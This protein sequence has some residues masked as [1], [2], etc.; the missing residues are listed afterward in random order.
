R[1]GKQ[2]GMPGCVTYDSGSKILKSR[3]NGL[4]TGLFVSGFLAN[5]AMHEVDKLVDTEL[6]TNK[7]IAH[8]RF[9]DDHTILARDFDQLC[10]W[11]KWYE[12]LLGKHGV[13]PKINKDKYDPPSLGKWI[14]ATKKDAP[15]APK[16]KKNYDLKRFTAISDT[17]LDGKNPTKL[18]TKTL[19]QVSAIAATD[20]H[21]LDDEDLQERLNML[22]WLLL[23]N[24]S[25][26]EIRPDTRAAFAAGQIV[27]MVQLLIREEEQLLDITRKLADLEAN[28]P[29]PESTTPDVIKKHDVSIHQNKVKAEELYKNYRKNEKIFLRHHFK[30]LIESFEKFPGKARLFFRLLQYCRIT[31]YDGLSDLLK[32]I[33][34][35]RKNKNVVWA[36][37]Y[38]GLLLQILGKNIFACTKTLTQRGSLRSD[39]S[40]ALNHIEDLTNNLELKSFLDD[41]NPRQWFHND[42]IIEFGVSMLVASKAIKNTPS[43]MKLAKILENMGKSFAGVSSETSHEEWI[44]NTGRSPGVWAFQ[45][46]TNINEREESSEVWKMFSSK[47]RMSEKNDEMAVRLYPDELSDEIW[48]H[49]LGPQTTLPQNDSGWVL[50]AINNLENRRLQA[51]SSGKIPFIEAAKSAESPLKYITLQ[52]WVNKTKK[53]DSFDPRIGEWTALEIIRQLI[54]PIIEKFSVP[55]EAEE[56]AV[57]LEA[58]DHI[59][60][61]NVLLPLKWLNGWPNKK[62][63]GRGTWEEWR[64]F[65]IKDNINK[66]Q[67]RDPATLIY[68]YRFE[69][70]QN[71]GNYIDPWNRRI[72][73]VGF[74]LLG[75]LK[76]NLQVPRIW[77]IRG[78][79][80]IF[81]IPYTQ[82]YNSL[83]ISTPTLLLIESCISART[84]ETRAIPQIPD[85]FGHPVGTN[86][87]DTKFDP[88]HIAGVNPLLKEIEKAQKILVNNQ[89]SV[90]LNQPRQLIPF[91]IRDFATGN[92]QEGIES[93]P[94]SLE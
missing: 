13:G 8:F 42:A 75:L 17:K 37:Y 12:E 66:V 11:I 55:L 36:N 94:T 60:P 23:A 45:Y 18:M 78:N 46:E 88:P 84:A 28:R 24:I 40:A 29:K 52:D 22:E 69:G 19:T 68:D 6:D 9:V 62:F 54:I 61:H 65:I 83:A 32:C 80:N 72:A 63:E 1:R 21:I 90:S 33:E 41:T 89:I 15:T 91:H 2:H 48:D 4:P 3:V 20:I 71:N 16:A 82:W 44:S 77:N 56:F 92:Q 34:N 51:L 31:G 25:E 5:I 67:I 76:Q 70:K 39:Q 27:Q 43:M 7:S 49:F 85:L 81:K 38:S 53:L 59:N 57:S 14:V 50:E 64:N 58:L 74:L 10:K 93:D 30:L 87:N 79:E 86:L 47:F 73:A 35:F 26:H